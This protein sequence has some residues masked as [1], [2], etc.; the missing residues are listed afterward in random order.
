L[1]CSGLFAGF[2]IAGD[3]SHSGLGQVDAGTTAA[4]QPRRQ[5]AQI[6]LMPYQR[7]R[8]DATVAENAS[9]FAAFAAGGK[10]IAQA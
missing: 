4:D 1:K 7:R 2:I 8:I 3:G 10:L 5:F 6:G 9:Q